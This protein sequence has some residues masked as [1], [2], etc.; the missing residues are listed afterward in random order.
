M[1]LKKFSAKIQEESS[2]FA[3]VFSAIDSL[4]RCPVGLDP[5]LE[6]TLPS[7]VAYHHAG[8]TVSTSLHMVLIDLQVLSMAH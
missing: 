8:L 2:E 7:G 1:Y 5:V 6:E 3:D 4:R